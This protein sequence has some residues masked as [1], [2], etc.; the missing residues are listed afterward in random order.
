[1][2]RSGRIRH[3]TFS[4][5]TR[6]GWKTMKLNL[7]VTDREVVFGDDVMIV[8]KTDLKGVITYVNHDFIEISGYTE[9]ELLGANHH[10]VRHPDVPSE[11]FEDLWTK[12]K[13]GRPWTGLI[14]NRCKNGD[15]YWV[16]ANVAP[17]LES[18]KVTGYLSVRYKPDRR[19]VEKIEGYHRERKAGRSP[20]PRLRERLALSLPTRMMGLQVL[21][22]VTGAT[23]ASAGLMGRP[24]LMAAVLVLSVATVWLGGR[25]T[26]GMVDILNTATRCLNAMAQEDY[27]T[28]ID[29]EGGHESGRMLDALKSAQIRLGFELAEIKRIA[30]EGRC[31]KRTLDRV[32]TGVMLADQEG[33][34]VYANPSVRRILKEAESDLRRQ[35]PDFDASRP[36]GFN[37]DAFH[38]TASDRTN[39]TSDP[40]PA[41]LELGARKLRVITNPVVDGQGHPIGSAVEWTDLTDLLA[42]QEKESRMA[43]ENTR[44]R[45]ALDKCSTAVM[46]ADNDNVIIYGNPALEDMFTQ[47][48]ADIRKD[49]PHFD[50]GTL[51]GGKT[52]QFIVGGPSSAPRQ[53]SQV[54]ENLDKTIRTRMKLGGHSFAMTVNAVVDD[55]GQRLGSVM[56]WVDRTAELAAEKEVSRLVREA[57][58]GNLTERAK[59]DIMPEGFLRD[60]GEGI[61]RLLDVIVHP[62]NEIVRV[63][64]ALA[65]G[66]LTQKISAD[67]TGVFAKLKD[68]ANT[69]VDN[70]A[71]SV[72]A[73]KE[74][75]DAINAAAKDIA[76]G[77]QDLSHRTEEQASSLEQTASSMEELSSTVKQNADNAKQANQMA[78]AASDVAM[79]GGEVVQ[80]VV[81][82]MQGINESSRKIVDI[83]SVIDGIAFQTNILALN[84]AVEAARAG[85]QGRGFAVVAGEVRNLAQRSAA[86]AKEIKG[87]INDSVDKVEGG[88]KLV[89]EAGRTMDE[90]VHS[91]KRV[92]DIMAEI[93]AASVEQSSGIEQ[94]NQAIAQM[95][96][97]TQQNA[98]LVEQAAASA[99]SLEDQAASLALSVSRFK[100]DTENASRAMAR[101][102]QPV[103][104]PVLVHSAPR[105]ASK[106]QLAHAGDTHEDGWTEF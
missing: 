12:L 76:H 13:A 93:A 102:S 48:E 19:R 31:L 27:K 71:H 96:D 66:D 24:D 82:T 81:G 23:A 65:N 69:S 95:D 17:I 6:T 70:L 100:L 34:V 9:R 26:Q 99:E 73:I 41:R 2:T 4:D 25:V 43:T 18:G 72:L 56:E 67:Y 61:N 88:A 36:I 16:E 14:K 22:L 15:Y 79:R 90:I 7:P 47:A 45:A 29:L 3:P 40:E 52:D 55:Q 86:A 37:I 68:D 80:R 5:P 92:T 8:S 106:G 64:A 35:R 28:R 60:T 57:G 51:V 101:P 50:A 1:M 44:I 75:T 20:Q 98:A 59:L 85:E 58:A 42:M 87:L 83:I 53:D 62:V 84:A 54:L 39:L 105:T 97:V 63:L 38:P 94:V 49:L 103:R 104:K 91:V 11:T 78:V 89:E 33:N 74:A 32:S 21:L 30:E 77:N 46:I 10:I